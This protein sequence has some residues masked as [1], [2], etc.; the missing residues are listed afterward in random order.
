MLRTLLFCHVN[1]F[2]QNFNFL[3]LISIAIFYVIYDWITILGQ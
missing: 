3:V 2:I 1:I